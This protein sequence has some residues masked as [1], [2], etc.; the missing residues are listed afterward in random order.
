M[1]QEE[2]CQWFDIWCWWRKKQLPQLDMTSTIL[3]RFPK[4][5]T[6]I[7][8]TASTDVM[9]ETELLET[10]KELNLKDSNMIHLHQKMLSMTQVHDKSIS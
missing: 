7:A 5:S 9:D 8:S 3:S 1:S 6:E 10:I 2:W 4:I